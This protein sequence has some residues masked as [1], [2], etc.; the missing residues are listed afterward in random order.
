MTVIVDNLKLNDKEEWLKLWHQADG[1]S[2]KH[3]RLD[4]PEATW[5]KITSGG[6]QLFGLGLRSNDNN[7]LVG[8]VL[9]RFN[10]CV[11][12]GGDECFICDL[13]V[14]PSFRRQ[15]GGTQLMQAVEQQARKA[16]VERISWIANSKRPESVS[17]YSSIPCEKKDHE[18]YVHWL[19]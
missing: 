4:I 8:Y 17:F 10:F 5:T 7:R 2:L 19:R 16:K 13:F 9:Y 12:A 14:D 15:G 3:N 18:L 11:K 6:N 1:W